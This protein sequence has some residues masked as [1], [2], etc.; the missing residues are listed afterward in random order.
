MRKT[1]A[2]NAFI[3][4]SVGSLKLHNKIQCLCLCA[5][6]CNIFL[7]IKDADMLVKTS[8]RYVAMH[9]SLHWLTCAVP[10]VKTH[11]RSV[12]CKSVCEQKLQI[13]SQRVDKHIESHGEST[14]PE[15]DPGV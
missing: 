14:L 8:S 4:S 11:K 3:L 10:N 9:L 7:F 6:F 15:L 1:Q 13:M 5:L 2:E 12:A